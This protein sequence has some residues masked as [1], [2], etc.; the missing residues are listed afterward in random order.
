M[1]EMGVNTLREYH[2]PFK[3]NKEVLRKMHQQYGFFVIMGI[4]SGNTL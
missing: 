4:S 3:P 1:K 2:Q